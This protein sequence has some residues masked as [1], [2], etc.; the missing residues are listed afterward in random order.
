MREVKNVMG[1]GGGGSSQSEGPQKE[2]NKR[3]KKDGY[4]L[5]WETNE[6][7]GIGQKGKSKGKRK[8][9]KKVKPLHLH[10]GASEGCGVESLCVVYPVPL[11]WTPDSFQQ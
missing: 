4:S 10:L 2:K 6:S 9:K 8:K 1:G 7:W 11:I 3:G 5:G